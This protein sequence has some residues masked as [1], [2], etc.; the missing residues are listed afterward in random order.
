[1]PAT[2]GEMNFRPLKK[3]RYGKD[4]PDKTVHKFN[5]RGSRQR[6]PRSFLIYMKDS[7]SKQIE[8]LRREIIAAIR[9]L[10]EEHGKPEIDIPDTVDA[11]YIICFGDDAEPNECVV[12]NV[13]LG[14]TDLVITAVEKNSND[15]VFEICGPFELGAKNLDWLNEI[16]ETIQ[17][18]TAESNNN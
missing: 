14:V 10:L 6:L 16:Y 17:C 4:I 18:L 5:P 11:I 1:M 2:N 9:N 3:R 8:A 12:T 15:L 7:F 13:A